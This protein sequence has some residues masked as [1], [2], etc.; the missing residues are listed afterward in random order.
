MSSALE[1]LEE[2]VAELQKQN[3]I[4]GMENEMLADYLQRDADRVASGEDADESYSD[5]P[6]PQEKGKKQQ[7]ARGGRQ[8]Q[9]RHVRLPTS[10][11]LEEKFR[12]ANQEVEALNRDIEQ[13]LKTS[14]QNLD[15]LR[16]LMEETDIRTAEV[17]R[18]AYE[19][20]RDIVVGAE[21]PRTGKT[22]A[23]KVLKYMEDK[24]TQKDMLINKLLMKNQA[25]KIAIKKSD[26]AYKSKQETGD[27]LQYIDFHQLQIENQQFV[28]KIEEATQELLDLKRRSGRTVKILNNMKK[29]LSSLTTEAKFLE[30]EIKERK[31]MLAKTEHD[32]VKIVE[33]KEGARKELR[34]LRAQSRQTSEMPQVV[35]YVSQKAEEYELEAQKR[36]WTRKVELAET[37][38]KRIRAAL[39]K[40]SFKSDDAAVIASPRCP[41]LEELARTCTE[42]WPTF[43]LANE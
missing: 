3:E 21:N 11:T 36:N 34:K 38:A 29:K 39:R 37:A 7:V 22:M 24:L 41:A 35:D 13:T 33:E 32:I 15:I 2:K 17:K 25:Y 31:A 9:Q 5:M 1:E 28:Q 10:L 42:E 4:L 27:D 23:E 43:R 6:S 30:D 16:A 14:E 12:I 8:G 40:A 26:N 18:D 20:R 19:F